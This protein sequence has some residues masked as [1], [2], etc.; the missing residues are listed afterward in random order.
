MLVIPLGAAF[1]LLLGVVCAAARE[2]KNTS[3]QNLKDVRAYTQMTILGSI[4][5]LE[6]DFVVRRRKRLS[7]LGWTTATLASIVVMVG[8]VVYYFAKQV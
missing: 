1:G 2:M 6:N 4:P 3:L 7:W 5:L 8:S